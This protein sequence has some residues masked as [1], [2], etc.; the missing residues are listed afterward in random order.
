[1]S[2]APP[3]SHAPLLTHVDRCD[4]CG[5]RAYVLA[6]I[7]WGGGDGALFFCRHDWLKN[8]SAIQPL[9]AALVDETDQLT[10]HIRDDKGNR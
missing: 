5:A 4:R 10:E 1:M 7:V 9:L 8:K 2:I 3:E 6:I